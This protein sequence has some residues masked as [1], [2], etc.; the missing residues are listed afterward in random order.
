MYYLSEYKKDK[1]TVYVKREMILDSPS[2]TCS[3]DKEQMKKEY[4]EI[5]QKDFRSQIIYN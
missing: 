4:F 2:M 1:K 5:L 3:A